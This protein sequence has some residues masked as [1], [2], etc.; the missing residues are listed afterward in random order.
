MENSKAY[1]DFQKEALDLLL[2]SPV[3]GLTLDIGHNHCSG[4]ADEA[5]IRERSSRL[6]HMHMHD[7]IGS[8]QDHQSLG[9][10]EMDIPAYLDL[11]EQCCDTVLLEVK[12]LEGLRS[13]VAWLREREKHEL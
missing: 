10:G 11:A 1:F 4:Y 9:Q 7:A 13:S 5:W 3:F 6:H 8:K 12:T 2:E